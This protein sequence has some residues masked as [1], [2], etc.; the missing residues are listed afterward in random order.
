MYPIYLDY[1]ATT[2]LDPRVLKSMIDGMNEK[3]SFGN[4]S[5]LHH[6]GR[7]A[8]AYIEEARSKIAHYL[9]AD[10]TE[11]IFT[12]GATEANNL[13]IKGIAYLYQ[14]KGKHIVTIKTEHK[15]V[16]DA[17]QHLEKEGFSVTYLTPEVDG[18]IDI[19]KFKAAIR[20]DTILV[21]VMHVNNE[22]GVIHDLQTMSEITSSQH[23]FFH[24]DAAQ[25]M[26]KLSLDVSTL[27]L[28][29]IS[30]SAHKVYGPKGIGALYLRKKPRVRV[31]PLF[32]G[33]GHEQG[34]R[35]GTLPTYQIIGMGEAYHLASMEYAKDS[36]RITA[37]RDD[38]LKALSSI[39][40]I[41]LNTAY[42][43]TVPHIVNLRFEGMLADAILKQLPHIATSTAS[44]CQGKGIEGSYVLRAMGLSDASIK[45]SIRFS[46]GRFTTKEEIKKAS[47]MILDLFQT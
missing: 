1:A 24:V 4:A 5:S 47:K 9:H 25:S 31:L 2:P 23:I 15:A 17:C 14:R 10:P 38:F 33:G 45:S 13:A 41:Q 26:G 35:S 7:K 18:R 37:L 6:Y 39:Q 42:S 30:L 11:I 28:D 22:T 34:L 20:K 8:K 3:D 21:S 27:P 44:A 32:H 29:L 40:T 19:D 46:F 36:Q 43:L 12:S 16:L